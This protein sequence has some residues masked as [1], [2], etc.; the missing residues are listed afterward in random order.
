MK[1]GETFEQTVR[2][3]VKE[4]YSTEIQKLQLVSVSN[5][6]RKHDAKLTHWIA[7][8]F[9]LQLNPKKVK[10][11]DSEKMDKIG[12]FKPNNLPKPLHSMFLTHLQYV[13]D[14]GII[15]SD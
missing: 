3:E 8:L 5:V 1:M 14:A 7:V 4:E 12:W 10:I 13:K 11:G 2:R 15:E 9:A 6:L